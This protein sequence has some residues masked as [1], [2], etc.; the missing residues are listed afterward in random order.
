MLSPCTG[1]PCPACRMRAWW[2]AETGVATNCQISA[3]SKYPAAARL[4]DELGED[5]RET[6]RIGQ[7]H[8]V[9]PRHD[10]RLPSGARTSGRLGSRQP[11]NVV[12]AREDDRVWHV[13]PVGQRPSIG[14]RPGPLR[15]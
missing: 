11:Y 2:H 9:S 4:R 3:I 6:R 14:Y 15:T 8:R 10:D 1:V 12:V 7:K 5:F 13:G